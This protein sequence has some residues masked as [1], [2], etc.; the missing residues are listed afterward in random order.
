M[1]N[2]NAPSY[3]G[4]GTY[5]YRY[6]N[7]ESGEVESVSVIFGKDHDPSVGLAVSEKGCR[8]P[9][10]ISFHALLAAAKLMAEISHGDPCH[11]ILKTNI[12]KQIVSAFVQLSTE[13]TINLQKYLSSFDVTVK[14]FDWP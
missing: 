4:I 2:L 6:P 9:I 14:P 7:L 8:A 12:L 3:A 13:L 10:S 5:K 1:E 11:A